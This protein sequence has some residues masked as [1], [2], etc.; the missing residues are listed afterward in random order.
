MEAETE[1]ESE[2]EI[3]QLTKEFHNTEE[4]DDLDQVDFAI[5]RALVANGISYS[6]L[7]NPDFLKMVI[8]I[9]N[10]PKGYKPPSIDR[11]RTSFSR[12][13]REVISGLPI[14]LAL[15]VSSKD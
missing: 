11:A 4:M 10:A 12:I 6:V 8:A 9:N 5:V 15:F 2:R 1:S 3:E 13:Q 7:Q 14:L